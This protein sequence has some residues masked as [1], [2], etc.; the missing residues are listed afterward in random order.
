MR[1]EWDS[2]KELTLPSIK[3]LKTLSLQTSFIYVVQ[4]TYFY[5]YRTRLRLRFLRLS[6]VRSYICLIIASVCIQW[7]Y[8]HKVCWMKLTSFTILCSCA[9]GSQGLIGSI[10][11]EAQGKVSLCMVFISPQKKK[12]MI[13]WQIVWVWGVCV[14]A[15]CW[16]QHHITST[17]RVRIW[18][19]RVQLFLTPVRVLMQYQP[20]KNS[21]KP[22][23]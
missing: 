3:N 9:T 16:V 14:H 1:Y 10:F 6:P 17:R 8:N 2:H 11:G 21:S 13:T 20:S 19:R 4:L 7:F 12:K 5:Q 22:F 18:Q 23:L 15:G